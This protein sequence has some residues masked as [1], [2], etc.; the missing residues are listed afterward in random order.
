MVRIALDSIS[1]IG[2]LAQM[3]AVRPTIIVDY[4]RAFPGFI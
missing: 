2:K 4:V 3:K 1:A